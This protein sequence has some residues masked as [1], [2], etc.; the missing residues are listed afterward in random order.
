M[1]AGRDWLNVASEHE[2]ND[3]GR[4][5][6]CRPHEVAVAV[7]HEAISYG[8]FIENMEAGYV[9]PMLK[10]AIFEA[11]RDTVIARSIA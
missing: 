10:K 8:T 2:G 11:V 5:L 6:L 7:A 9:L 3:V 1:S 4:I